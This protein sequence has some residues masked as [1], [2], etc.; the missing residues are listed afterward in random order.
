RGGRSEPAAPDLAREDLSSQRHA[1]LLLL[2]LDPLADLLA[3]P[4]CL[5]VCQP[6]TRRLG[7]RGGEDFDRI[8]VAQGPMQRGD[9]AV[10]ASAVA[11]LADF[12]VHHER[13][14][15]RRRAL[16][17]PLHVAARRKDEDLV[18]IEVDLQELEEFLGGVRVLLQLDQL[19][20]PRQM[21][22]ELVGALA[23]FLIEPTGCDTVPRR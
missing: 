21:V 3:G 11:V 5:N 9:A 13:E 10:Y 17:Q 18:L 16:R 19:P 8:A 15:D 2:M 20:E 1:A 6:I 23:V 22:I 4:D 7:L 14:I 12:R